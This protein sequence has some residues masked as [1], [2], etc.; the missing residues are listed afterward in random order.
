MSFVVLGANG[1]TGSAA[2]EELLRFGKKVTAVVRS[3]EKGAA[4]QAK[5]AT[6]AIGDHYDTAFLE[7]TFKGHDGV[8]FQIIGDMTAVEFAHRQDE[9]IESIV[10]AIEKS[11]IKNVAFLSSVGAEHLTGVGHIDGLARAEHRLKKH[12][13]INVLFLRAGYFMENT[14]YFLN[15]IVHQGIAGSSLKPD[16][17]VGLVSCHDIGVFVGLR[18]AEGIKGHITYE[19]FAEEKTMTEITAEIGKAI[20]I[21]DLKYIQFPAPAVEANLASFGWSPKAIASYLEMTNAMDHGKIKYTEKSGEF[22][23][24]PTPFDK[25]LTQGFVAA[26]HAQ[27]K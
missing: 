2:V 3:A 24:A 8:F 23:K 5:G 7:K 17:K 22:L 10:G 27:K 13:H 11:G 21:P 25:W 19:Y 12:G 6:L 26:Y 15:P 9:A 16:T 1:H 14:F 18:L 20:G 4:L